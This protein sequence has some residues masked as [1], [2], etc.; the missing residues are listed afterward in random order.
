MPAL[1][2]SLAGPV[3]IGAC[4]LVVTAAS[5][6]HFLPSGIAS[7]VAGWMVLSVPAGIAVGHC[8]LSEEVP[9]PLR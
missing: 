7:L 5:A 4:L 6:L 3:L 8:V 9:A 2:D 1:G